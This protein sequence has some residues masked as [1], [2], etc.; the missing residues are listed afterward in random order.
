MRGMRKRYLILLLFSGA[1]W[2]LIAGVLGYAIPVFGDMWLQHLACAILASLVVGI[3]FRA[4]I[5]HWSGW[6]WYLLPLLTLLTG[7]AVFGFLLTGSWQL[8]ESLR[9]E[10]GLEHDAFYKLPLAIVFYSMTSFLPVL[11]LL[12]LL[13]QHLLRRQMRLWNADADAAGVPSTDPCRPSSPTPLSR[14]P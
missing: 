10:V 1:G 7:T 14:L 4:P 2:F 13:T 6:R 8:T 12:A 3:T 5:L 11:Y 9:G